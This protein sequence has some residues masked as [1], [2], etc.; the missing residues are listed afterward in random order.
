MKKTL[1]EKKELAE[2]LI[3]YF[4]KDPVKPKNNKINQQAYD[5]L[6]MRLAQS[7]DDVTKLDMNPFEQVAYECMIATMMDAAPHNY[8]L[9]SSYLVQKASETKFQKAPDL[10]WVEPTGSPEFLERAD[11]KLIKP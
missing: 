9:V 7:I 8:N 5:I 10:E 3:S 2:K 1:E 4:G 6:V 11:A